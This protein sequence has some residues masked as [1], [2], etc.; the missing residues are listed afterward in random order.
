[1]TP[2]CSTLTAHYSLTTNFRNAY[3]GIMYDVMLRRLKKAAY[4]YS[5]ETRQKLDEVSADEEEPQATSSEPGPQIPRGPQGV[6]AQP[7]ATT[8]GQDAYAEL[9]NLRLVI[10]SK[11]A[12]ENNE[13]YLKDVWPTVLSTTNHEGAKKKG[14]VES[15][16]ATNTRW[17]RWEDI[18][19]DPEL[20]IGPAQPTS[21][22]RPQETPEK[23]EHPEWTIY[24]DGSRKG[25]DQSAYWGFI[26][27]QDGK[28]RCRQKGKAPGSAQA[29]EVTAVL[30]GLLELV[31]R[32]IKSARLV[33]DSYYCAQALREDLAI[34][35]E[36]GFETAKGKPVAHKDLWKKIAELKLQLEIDVEHQKA[37]THEGAHWRGNDEVDCYSWLSA[38]PASKQK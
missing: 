14:T 30:E 8:T 23:P 22:K 16:K 10:R 37:H 36:N 29:G 6:S 1:M 32:K 27:K 9:K 11:N 2:S 3:M 25:S 15:T 28:E 21:K 4:K 38:A 13:E 7:P 26:L 34:W 18:L 17:G 12:D 20:E 33:T 24:T 31:K 19:L 5:R 35:E